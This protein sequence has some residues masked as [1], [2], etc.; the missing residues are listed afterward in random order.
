MSLT[1]FSSRLRLP[2]IEPCVTVT[3]RSEGL[4][5]PP[6]SSWARVAASLDRSAMR[7]IVSVSEKCPSQDPPFATGLTWLKH[8]QSRLVPWTWSARDNGFSQSV[9]RRGPP[10]TA[11]W[12]KRVTAVAVE[13]TALLS[14]IFRYRHRY[15]RAH[16][17]TTANNSGLG[18]AGDAASRPLDIQGGGQM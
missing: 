15:S 11:S 1:L 8:Q 12:R 5:R 3:G 13:I 17:W 4:P 9:I 16:D 14:C 7:R 10:Q 2:G 6:M 18:A